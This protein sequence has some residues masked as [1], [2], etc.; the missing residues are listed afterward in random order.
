MTTPSPRVARFLPNCRFGMKALSFARIIVFLIL[1]AT[2]ALP[3]SSAGRACPDATIPRVVSIPLLNDPGD[4]VTV[5]VDLNQ[6]TSTDLVVNISSLTPGNWYSL[7]STVTVPAGQSSVT[8]TAI[9]SPCA[10]GAVEVD[11]CANGVDAGAFGI[12][13][14]L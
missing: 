9:I 13:V 3:I 2:A 7:P 6:T 10:I 14:Q 4:G 1:V 11:A 5:E 8:F 12:I